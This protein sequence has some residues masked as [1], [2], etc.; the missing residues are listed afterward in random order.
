MMRYIIIL[1]VAFLTGIYCKE[2]PTF[3]P[4]NGI[5]PAFPTNIIQP[6]SNLIINTTN[7]AFAETRLVL[8]WKAGETYQDGFLV[9]KF[10]FIEN[11]FIEIGKTVNREVRYV[12]QT[13]DKDLRFLYRVSAFVEISSDSLKKSL[14]VEVSFNHKIEE[15]EIDNVMKN[16]ILLTTN[17]SIFT[18]DLKIQIERKRGTNN[19]ELIAELEKN[20]TT[21]FDSFDLEIGEEI[22]YRAFGIVNNQSTDTLET[23]KYVLNLNA[24]YSI[25]IIRSSSDS[26]IVDI[27]HIGLVDQFVLELSDING[28][29]I[30]KEV[31]EVKSNG[32]YK[33]NLF[34]PGDDEKYK[35]DIFTKLYN[36]LSIPLE[37]T[38]RLFPSLEL[39]KYETF[40][41]QFFYPIIS[42]NKR[43]LASYK[44]NNSS[45]QLDL[46]VWNLDT[47]SKIASINTQEFDVGGIY[48]DQ[49]DDAIYISKTGKIE[50]WDLNGA[51][52]STYHLPNPIYYPRII[53]NS[54]KDEMYLQLPSPSGNEPERY[55]FLIFN[56]DSNKVVKEISFQGGQLFLSGEGKYL[57]IE[58]VGQNMNTK[59]FI[60]TD[61]SDVFNLNQDGYSIGNVIFENENLYIWSPQ[62]G[63]DKYDLTNNSKINNIPNYYSSDRENYKGLLISDS[64]YLLVH[65]GPYFSTGISFIDVGSGNFLTRT[66]RKNLESGSRI[67]LSSEANIFHSNTLDKV[68]IVDNYTIAKYSFIYYWGIEE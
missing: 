56:F 54:F 33:A 11:K 28:A 32:L 59:V 6:P 62:L 55:G 25:D 24:P 8:S 48:F 31:I 14:P 36:E 52:I 35:L 61:F 47:F 9:E 16:G 34:I 68:F 37:E 50:K 12:D 39:T 49:L 38:V 17:H 40:S 43:Y 20:R 64:N 21:F 53:V 19:F 58:G 46:E 29:L 18:D 7:I 26:L 60:T 2:T 27:N 66:D 42:H 45:N 10:D 51:L 41:E 22:Y 15:F 57:L 30:T 67:A 65:D 1:I 44:R 13:S 23:N 63:L 3:T 4:D 5:D